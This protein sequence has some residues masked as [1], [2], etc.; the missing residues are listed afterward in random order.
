MNENI[1]RKLAKETNIL[2]LEDIRLFSIDNKLKFLATSR[3][4]SINSTNSIVIGDYNL[5][6]N[7]IENG[8]IIESPNPEDCEKNWI[9]IENKIIYKWFPL[10]IGE[11]KNDKLIID[12]ITQTPSIFKYLRGSSNI[13]EYNNEWW[14]IVHGVKYTTPRK[15]YHMIVVLDKNYKLKKYTVPF[16][17]DT[18]SIEYCLGLLIEKDIMYMTASRY[19][20]DPIIVKINVKDIMKLFI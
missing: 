15:Y 20:K 1:D 4:F 13:V 3:E 2:G 19:D 6:T 8:N 5:E 10:Q 16:Y 9:S 17:F 12:T 18:Y 7:T 14:T 11:I